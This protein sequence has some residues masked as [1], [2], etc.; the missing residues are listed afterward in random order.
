MLTN[1]IIPQCIKIQRS[2]YIRKSFVEIQY[3]RIL[4]QG[5]NSFFVSFLIRTLH[6]VLVPFLKNVYCIHFEEL[7][8]FMCFSVKVLFFFLPHG[9]TLEGSS[10]HE[11]WPHGSSVHWHWSDGCCGH[12]ALRWIHWLYWVCATDSLFEVL[13]PRTTKAY[14][15]SVRNITK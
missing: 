11:E 9:T 13:W 14:L 12:R 5:G 15:V 2:L 8:L 4:F 1:V 10:M 3:S 6:S 7:L